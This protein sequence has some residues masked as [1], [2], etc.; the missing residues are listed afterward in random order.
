MEDREQLIL[1]SKVHSSVSSKECSVLIV[2][3]G[4]LIDLPASGLRVWKGGDLKVVIVVIIIR[5]FRAESL[6]IFVII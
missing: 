5:Q 6:Y 3:T 1:G 2:S 4:V